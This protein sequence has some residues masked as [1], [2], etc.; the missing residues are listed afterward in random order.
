M[1]NVRAVKMNQEALDN[2][3]IKIEEGF[4][5]ISDLSEELQNTIANIYY[6]AAQIAQSPHKA[7]LGNGIDK[8]QNGIEDT[9]FYISAV[10]SLPG[11]IE[12]FREDVLQ[13]GNEDDINFMNEVFICMYKYRV[14]N[15]LSK[16]LFVVKM[17]KAFSKKKV[18][19]IPDLYKQL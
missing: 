11:I 4:G 1:S 6:Q 2:A 5:D 16:P 10:E 17:I 13:K 9:S 14:K 18:N 19:E 3:R 7:I 8:I 15:A 12:A